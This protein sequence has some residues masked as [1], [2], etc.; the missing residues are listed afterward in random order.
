MYEI[1]VMIFFYFQDASDAQ[2]GKPEVFLTYQ[3]GSALAVALSQPR[4]SENIWLA[5][6]TPVTNGTLN[7]VVKWC[8]RIVRGC[9]FSI[10]LGSSVDASKVLCSGEGLR[11][12]VIGREIKSWIDTRR[13]GRIFF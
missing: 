1:F 2:N 6:Y 5:T 13:A 12:G 3:D 7:L 11:N 10:V 8:G 9:P 4:L